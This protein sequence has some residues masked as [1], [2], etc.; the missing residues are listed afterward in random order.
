[1]KSTIGP[2]LPLF[3]CIGQAGESEIYNVKGNDYQG[4]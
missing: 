2:I 4:Y 3:T 1:M